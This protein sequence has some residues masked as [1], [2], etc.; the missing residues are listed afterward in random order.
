MFKLPLQKS[1]K[2]ILHIDADAFFAT[3]EQVLNP[4]LKGKPL[5][6]GGPSR[7]HGIVSAASYEAKKFGIYSGMP[8][9]LATRKCPKAV[10]VNAHF[11]KY[12][13]FSQKMYE[14]M[15]GFTPDVEMASIDEAYLDLTGC[16]KM[17]KQSAEKLAR[18]I[19]MEINKRVGISVS[20]GLASSKIVA[21]VASSLNKPHKLTVIPFG[22]E[23]EFLA[24]LPLSV[25]P[26]VGRKT[27][28]RLNSFGFKNIE[29]IAKLDIK[30]LV[31]SFGIEIIPLWK[32]C[33]GIDDA[34]V[35]SDVA[36]PKS[37][38]KEN[39]FYSPPDIKGATLMIREMGA[40][41]LAKLRRHGLKAT[42]IF[43]RIRYRNEE[44]DGPIFAD[45]SFQKH[46][47]RPSAL[48]NEIL[49]EMKKFFLEKIE[50]DKKIRLVGVGVGGL[51]SVYN[52]SLFE[53][54]REK[55]KL[56]YAMDRVKN[57]YGENALRY[58]AD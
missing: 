19:L 55:D 35:V 42:I 53:N 26:G 41:V 40:K 20:G 36:E 18:T 44:K 8:M 54:G 49:P 45:F 5:L 11:S 2:F 33:Q 43:L 7:E 31:E 21:K 51:K 48:D 47:E 10:V 29:D 52:L 24:K 32:H 38:S 46:L 3:V 9:Y 17:H 12:G 58:G 23:I 34:E 37:I 39:T 28:P 14:V 22:K 27:L 15:L 57:L 4:S 56:F 30:K 1:K 25:L 13:E 50:H 16:E 6:V